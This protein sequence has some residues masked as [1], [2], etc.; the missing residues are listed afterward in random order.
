MAPMYGH[1]KPYN[2]TLRPVYIHDALPLFGALI[3]ELAQIWEDLLWMLAVK[4]VHEGV[5]SLFAAATTAFLNRRATSR[6]RART[7]DHA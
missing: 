3:D 5:T 2:R 4:S 7:R 6:R 1:R